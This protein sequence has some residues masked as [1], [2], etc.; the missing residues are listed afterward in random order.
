M[1]WIITGREAGPADPYIGNVSLL[2]HGDG[3]NGSTTIIDSSSN[4]QSVTVVGDAQISTAIAD[5]FGNTTGVIAFDGVGDGLLGPNDVSYQFGT[6]DFTV[7]FWVYM[8]SISSDYTFVCRAVSGA[9]DLFIQYRPSL[10]QALRVNTGTGYSPYVFDWLP[11]VNTWHHVAVT[12]AGENLRGFVD[13]TQIGSTAS[14]TG[15]IIANVPISIGYNNEAGSQ[16]LNGYIDD[17][18]ITKGIARYTANFTPP[19]APFPDI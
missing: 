19:T 3:A 8:N 6:E 10:S 7:E 11:L 5:P 15:N 18:R 13:G 2:L 4:V 12:R 16:Y 17:L 9:F 1:S 14:D